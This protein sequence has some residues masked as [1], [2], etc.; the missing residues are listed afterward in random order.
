MSAGIV[1]YIGAALVFLL[2]ACNTPEDVTGPETDTETPRPTPTAITTSVGVVTDTRVDPVGVGSR[3]TVNGSMP[4]VVETQLDAMEIVAAREQ[5]LANIYEQS[6]PSVV[7]VRAV[8]RIDPDDNQFGRDFFGGI[9][10]GPLDEFQ[11]GAGSGFV[12]DE[13]GHILTNWHV[14]ENSDSVSVVFADGTELDAELLGGDPDSDLAILK[15]DPALRELKPLPRGDLDDLRVGQMALA[16]GSPFGQ[17]FT[18]TS[19]IVSALGRTIRSGSGPYSIPLV[20]QTDA[21]INPGNS[22]GPL[23]DRRGHV[24][25]IN[26]QILSRSGGNSGVGFAVPIDIAKQVVPDLIEHGKYEYAWLGISGATLTSDVVEH[27][28]LPE[29]SRGVLIVKAIEDGP[30]EGAG[31]KGGEEE[32]TIDGEDVV[33]GG[34]VITAINGIAVRKMHDLISYLVENN[35]PGDEIE[36]DV[37]HSNG[38]TETITVTLGTRPEN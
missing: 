25:G 16:I 1:F 10:R 9:P 33:L 34:D 21:P 12:W 20:V 13:E 36:L 3:T 29:A 14:V 27:L 8:H 2:A 22:G 15:V 11:Q 37:L 30:A 38:E 35:R 26:T 5:V 19:G 23:L 28:G 6:L 31:I 4:S 24:I 32:V 7:F 17:D 18:L